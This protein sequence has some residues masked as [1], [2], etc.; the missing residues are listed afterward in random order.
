M[1]DVQVEI[2]MDLFVRCNTWEHG[3]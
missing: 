3:M 1:I 2:M